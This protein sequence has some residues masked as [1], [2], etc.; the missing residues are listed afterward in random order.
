MKTI[1]DIVFW[2]RKHDIQPTAQRLE[3]AELSLL[4]HQHFSADEILERAMSKGINVSRATIYN[5][6]NLFVEKKLLK[7]VLIDP[8]RVLYDSNTST[9]HHAYN[10]DTGELRDIEFID[11]HLEQLP[12]IPSTE[13]LDSIDLVFKVKNKH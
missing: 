4:T 2:L 10:V 13:V 8:S 12:D 9:H 11:F 1:D 5:T 7:E 3:L 6:L